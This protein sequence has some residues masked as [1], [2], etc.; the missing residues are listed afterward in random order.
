M[1]TSREKLLKSVDTP[2]ITVVPQIEDFTTILDP[3]TYGLSSQTLYEDSRPFISVHR[4]DKNGAIV[5]TES[6][7]SYNKLIIQGILEGTR[8]REQLIASSSGLEKVYSFGREHRL[9]N[10][11]AVLLD[12]DIVNPVNGWDGDGYRSWDSFYKNYAR[13]AACARNRWVVKLVYTGRTMFGGLLQST[14]NT[15]DKDPHRY[16]VSFIFYAILV[17]SVSTTTL[18]DFD[19]VAS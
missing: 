3:E 17:S 11:S 6:V 7:T 14:I 18:G 5:E 2:Q 16:D 4:I 10:V 19:F 1:K 8:E 13:I 12:T 15:T 9:F